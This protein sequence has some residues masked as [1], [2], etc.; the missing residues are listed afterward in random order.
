MEHLDSMYSFI[1]ILEPLVGS[2]QN[3][4]IYFYLYT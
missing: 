2:A 4:L 3:I 1:A